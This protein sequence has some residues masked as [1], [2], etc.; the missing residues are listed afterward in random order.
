MDEAEN[1]VLA[2]MTVPRSHWSQICSTN[3]LERLNAD[4]Q[5]VAKDRSAA[6]VPPLSAVE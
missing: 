5:P 4:Y 2:F 6:A 1:D 3:P